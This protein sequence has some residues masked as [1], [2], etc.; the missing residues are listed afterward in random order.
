MATN[1]E[2]H[3]SWREDDLRRALPVAQVQATVRYYGTFTDEIDPR[4]VST[5]K[6]PDEADT[7]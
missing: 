2:R 7:A 4:I 5:S 6:A 3:D 1:Q